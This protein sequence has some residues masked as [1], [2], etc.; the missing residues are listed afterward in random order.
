MLAGRHR[1]KDVTVTDSVR[2][3][4][5]VRHAKAEAHATTD[6][7]RPLAARGVRDARAAGQWLASELAVPGRGRTQALVSTAS[8]ARMTWAQMSDTVPAGVRMLDG[9][10]EAGLDEVVEML[11][12][13][14]EDVQTALVV[15]HN[16]TMQS[17]A[18]TLADTRSPGYEAMSERG[19][20]T[21]AIAVLDVPVPWHDLA[22]DT[23]PVRAFHVPER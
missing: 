5:V 23:C 9:L 22:P 10:Y 8:R 2:T 7:G 4:V 19:L 18:F 14:D 13:L 17:M 21:A 6:H 16:P 3:L 20:P 11:S 12:L 15:G 1:R